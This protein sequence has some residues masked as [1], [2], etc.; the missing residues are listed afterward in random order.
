MQKIRFKGLIL[1][2]ILL[3]IMF[4]ITSVIRSP[5][6]ST[7]LP[8]ALLPKLNQHVIAN[9]TPDDDYQTPWSTATPHWNKMDECDDKND[10][11][12]GSYVTANA[13]DDGEIEILEME[14]SILYVESV[15]LIKVHTYGRS[16]GNSNP[17]V[18]LTWD[19]GETD[20]Q[21][22]NLPRAMPGPLTPGWAENEFPV[23]GDQSDLNNLQVRYKAHCTG[24]IWTPYGNINIGSN[25]IDAFFCEVNY[26]ISDTITGINRPNGDIRTEWVSTSNP[27]PHYSR[28][29]EAVTKPT[30]GDG[31]VI[32]ASGDDHHNKI[33]EFVMSNNINFVKQ[34]S[35][36]E[37]NTFGRSFGNTNP[38]ISIY[39]NSEWTSW[40]T[41]NLPRSSMP[42]PLTPSWTTNTW[43]LAGDQKDI[44]NIRVQFKAQCTGW[45][46]TPF[47]NINIG[48]NIIDT[49]YCEIY[50]EEGI[51]IC[52]PKEGIDYS[53]Y[54]TL[55][56]EPSNLDNLRYVLNGDDQNPVY[57][58]EDH[59]LHLPEGSYSIQ[60]FGSSGG[61]DYESV[62]IN[63]DTYHNT[64]FSN[65]QVFDW[66]MD[67]V[68]AERL[69]GIT[70]GEGVKVLVID[71]GMDLDHTDLVENYELGKD[72]DNEDDTP[73]DTDGHGTNCAGIIGAVNNGVGII[74]AS[75]EVSLYVARIHLYSNMKFIT[76][77]GDA[78]QWGIDND[79]DVISMSL[80][81][82]TNEIYYYRS[83][84]DEVEDKCQAAYQAGITLCAAAGNWNS[85]ADEVTDIHY[86]AAFYDYIIP[87]GA[88]YYDLTLVGLNTYN[89]WTLPEYPEDQY[90]G[91]SCYGYDQ[92][93]GIVA[94]GTQISSPDL[95]NGY[96]TGNG[97]SYACPLVAGVCALLLYDNPDL[98]PS[99]IKEIL[100]NTAINL[101]DDTG[102]D[103]I[104]GWGL[105][106]AVA[107]L[108]YSQLNY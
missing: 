7:T 90:Y 92:D 102:W 59:V 47:G 56:V 12:D 52:S 31:V 97:T 57:F 11:P 15:S 88:L 35:K 1:S 67:M 86:P 70:N 60:V 49:V 93:E 78:I 32:T 63:F 6:N 38:K 44:D 91:G 87:V 46:W 19:G 72:F 34:V 33:E 3:G 8:Q 64:S 58:S 36:I 84:D 98:T 29:D 54:V 107:A 68:D 30:I 5:T 51:S 27:E 2:V 10:P 99:Q 77:L 9:I 41:V 104:Y 53:E 101:G 62:V 14:N 83:W 80:G 48:A 82:F 26:T 79:V 43:V 61:E 40:Q 75:P 37:I 106:D 96:Y 71:T 21:T 100:Y 23:S 95:D 20:Y 22:V 13:D 4:P 25:S 24:W 103:D 94:P 45:I 16:F 18:A 105:I 85:W 39:W 28:I 17:K 89:R 50:Y 108:E 81:Y 73:E 74:G 65:Q 69:W 76:N 55:D 66:G 42:G